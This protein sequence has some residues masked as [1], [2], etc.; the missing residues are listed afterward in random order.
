MS[1]GTLE[2]VTL[3]IG[4][5]RYAEAERLLGAV[6]PAV[7]STGGGTAAQ[8]L[9]TVRGM[10]RACLEENERVQ[11]HWRAA[12]DGALA[13]SALRHQL[14][15]TL[16]GMAQQ[17]TAQQGTEP[18]GAQPPADGPT[19]PSGRPRVAGRATVSSPDAAVSVFCLGPLRLY[20]RER[21]LGALPNRRARSVF[22]YLLLHRGRVT[23]KERLMG[24]FWPEA[25]AAQARNN[26]NVAV[27]GL[28][29][30]LRDAQL[31]E[32]VVLFHDDGYLLSPTLGM[33]VDLDEFGRHTD[34]ALGCRA[35]GDPSGAL[36]E[37]EAAES[38]YGGA[39]FADDPYEEWTAGPRREAEDRYVEVL[40]LLIEH[41]RDLHDDG[42]CARV[43]RKI[44][45]VQPV[46]ETAH[47]E[48]MRCYAA[49]GQQHLAVRQ[50]R[51]CVQALRSDLGVAPH[52]HTVRLYEEV[53]G[54][55]GSFRDRLMR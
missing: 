29:R 53:R 4:A 20:E 19:P 50:Y 21:P 46:N 55:F 13:E 40:G 26:L 30:F 44:L 43:S 35:S 48:L 9:A 38:L 1:R 36:R 11:E 28:R 37:L 14:I 49:L 15:A 5:G 12:T 27:H 17:G 22:K 52:P 2:L 54:R 3:L 7:L 32:G 34:A 10:C 41:Y 16:Q 6:E 18:S 31:R 25:T 51:D 47:R 23:P 39:L 24:L 8:A 42:A 45:D 33:W